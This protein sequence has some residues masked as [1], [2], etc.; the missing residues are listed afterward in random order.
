MLKGKTPLAI[1]LLLG[2]IAFAVS[3]SAIKRSEARAREGW[4]LVPVVVAAVDLSE[5]HVVAV[6]E[7][8]VRHI[9]EKFA[10]SSIVRPD[11]ASYLLGQS[12]L[13]PV[14]AGDPLLWTQF[15]AARASERLA[16]KIVRKT[17]AFTLPASGVRA[18]GGWIRPNDHVDVLLAFKDPTTNQ[19]VATTLMQDA[20]VLA[21]GAVT[22]TT[23]AHAAKEAQ[24]TYGDVTLIVDPEEAEL[25]ILA[26][27]LGELSLTLRNEQDQDRMQDGRHSTV[28]TLLDGARMRI[29][30][31]RRTRNHGVI[32]MRPDGVTT[33][34]APAVPGGSAQ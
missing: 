25:L 4:N 23:P 13:V 14:Q 30:G 28:A 22:G 21:T 6:D 33:S 24:R 32:V 12:I 26:L 9:P 11:S 31:D 15:E 5:G 3:Y 10:T 18:V 17:R 27:Q 7:L 1:A 16:T 20:L 19:A 2:V 29:A 34:S 8:Q